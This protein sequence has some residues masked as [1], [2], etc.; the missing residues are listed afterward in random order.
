MTH[1]LDS[2][3]YCSVCGSGNFNVNSAISKKCEDCGFEYFKNPVIGAVP[4]II[5]DN[6]KLLVIKRAKNPGK[7]TYGFPGGFADIKETTEQTNIDVEVEKYLFSIPS[8]YEYNKVEYFPLDFYFLCKIKDMSNI[9]LQ[10][11]EV[12]DI[13]FVDINEIKPE[14]FGL[15]ANQKAVEKLQ[16]GL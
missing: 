5:D 11:T 6:G 4:I 3:K 1:V 15:Y 9:K 2:F 16:Q 13:M 14:D 8:F 12:S 10:E 7:D